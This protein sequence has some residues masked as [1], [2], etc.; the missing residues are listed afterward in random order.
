MTPHDWIMAGTGAASAAALV[1]LARVGLKG[2]APDHVQ[3]CCFVCPRFDEVVACR[4]A[5]G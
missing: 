1:A 3:T 4:T 5:A 2:G